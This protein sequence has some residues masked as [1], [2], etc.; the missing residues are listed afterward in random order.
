MSGER[1]KLTQ[2]SWALG[3]LTPVGEP[4]LILPLPLFLCLQS[5]PLSHCQSAPPSPQKRRCPRSQERLGNSLA[6]C[7]Q[8][9]L[10]GWEAYTSSLL[11]SSCY[12]RGLTT[13]KAP[14]WEDARTVTWDRKATPRNTKISHV[15]VKPPVPSSPA[16]L[17]CQLNTAEWV[18]SADAR[19]SRGAQLPTRWGERFCCF[20]SLSF[21]VVYYITDKLINKWN[22]LYNIYAI[23]NYI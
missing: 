17:K 7:G 5:S 9:P 8:A 2:G 22:S 21:E 23:Y 4:L 20:K 15:G 1:E 16:Q 12:L 11:D 19:W 13:L 10:R 18:A 6:A 3:P 14:C